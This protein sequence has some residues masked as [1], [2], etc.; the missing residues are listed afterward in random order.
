MGYAPAWRHPA[1]E[2]VPCYYPVTGYRSREVNPETG[3]RALVFNKNDGF[4]DLPVTI[5]CGR[6][7]G[8]RL[9]RSS[10][11]AVRCHHESSLYENNCFLTLTYSDENLP[12]PPSVSIRSIQL[13]MK[14]LRKKTGRYKTTD[15]QGNVLD[16]GIRFFA[17][18]EYGDRTNRPHYHILLFNYDFPDKEKHKWVN[19]AS[20]YW[21]YTSDLLESVWPY[22]HC[23]I[24]SVSFN[25]A[26]YTARYVMKKVTG[27]MAEEHY[28]WVDPITGEIHQLHPE[29]LTMSRR[30]G[31]GADWI[32]KY[33]TDVWPEDHVV[34]D[35]KQFRPP[36]YYKN[37][38]FGD[39]TD[40][41]VFL[42]QLRKK[43]RKYAEK[44]AADTTPD[45]LRV[46]ATVREERIKQLERKL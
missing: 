23:T 26:A 10:E 14:R 30:P 46:R 2:P 4:E 18:G 27:P 8:C 28:Q 41:E 22:G 12:S 9:D 42:R 7:I 36:R 5:K 34:I 39:G 31:I 13:F 19:S 35:N 20:P 1:V 15:S 6:C 43:Q 25:S 37:I 16:P 29:F 21:L 11:W 24:G 45:R 44:H 3:R 33:H 40:H 38:Q 17:C 32:K